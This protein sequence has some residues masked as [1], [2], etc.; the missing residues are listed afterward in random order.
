MSGRSGCVAA[1]VSPAVEPVRPA[2]RKRSRQSK[3]PGRFVRCRNCE[4][5]FPGGE[6]PTLYGRRDARRYSESL[7][8]EPLLMAISYGKGRVF[9]TALGHSPNAMQGRG[10]QVTLTRGAEWAAT[11]KVTF[12]PLTA[13]ELPSD[14]AAVRETGVQLLQK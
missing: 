7:R 14:T 1:G 3:A 10:F 13:V 8:S 9:H 2:R 5:F 4:Y 11:G 6:T 12:P